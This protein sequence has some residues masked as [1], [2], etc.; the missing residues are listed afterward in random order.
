M[1][2]IA[3]L[4]SRD[5]VE[6]GSLARLAETKPRGGSQT[7]DAVFLK[8]IS[9]WRAELAKDINR[10]NGGLSQRE[11]NYAVQMTINRSSS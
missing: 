8:E 3:G 10:R 4:L 2:E 5:A 11:L 1:G 6:A 7:V 9:G